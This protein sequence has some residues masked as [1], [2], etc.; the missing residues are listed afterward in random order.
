MGQWNQWTD[1]DQPGAQAS[2]RGLA[3]PCGVE[4]RLGSG[5]GRASQGIAVGRHGWHGNL[6][7]SS[8]AKVR[9]FWSCCVFIVGNFDPNC[10]FFFFFFR[11]KTAG[12]NQVCFLHCWLFFGLALRIYSNIAAGLWTIAGSPLTMCRTDI[13]Y[14][15][16]YR[17]GGWG[18]LHR[19]HIYISI[20]FLCTQNG[21]ITYWINY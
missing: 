10:C 8:L 2:R 16:I 19:M 13:W 14:V 11:I 9:S 5:A 7:D 21:H 17:G 20:L 15:H 12:S 18:T 1:S 6:A 3:R 4:P